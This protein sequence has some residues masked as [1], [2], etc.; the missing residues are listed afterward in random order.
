MNR[1]IFLIGVFLTMGVSSAWCQLPACEALKKTS[2]PQ[3]APEETYQLE[4]K[5]MRQGLYCHDLA[6]FDEAWQKRAGKNYTNANLVTTAGYFDVPSKVFQEGKYA[7]IYY[8][9]H[10]TLGPVF[11]FRDNGKWVLDRTSVYQYIHYE[12]RWLAY[13]GDYPYLEMLKTVYP[14]EERTTSQGQKVFKVRE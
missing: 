14:L 11:L 1:K 5:M 12:D 8:P 10:P 6:I 3:S 13:D 9:D 7:V 2:Q 4:L